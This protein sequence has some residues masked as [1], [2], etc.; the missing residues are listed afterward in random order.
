MNLKMQ[1]IVDAISK[2]VSDYRIYFKIL[3]YLIILLIFIPIACRVHS[4]WAGVDWNAFEI[5]FFWLI[6]V[7]FLTVLVYLLQIYNWKKILSL[8]GNNISFLSSF[9]IEMVSQIGKYIPGKIGLVLTKLAECNR[10]G[11]SKK[12]ALIC[13]S[14]HIGIG[15]YFQFLIGLLTVPII[16]QVV[17]DPNITFSII[18]LIFVVV[19]GIV[20]IYPK[21]FLFF[22]NLF[23]KVTGK[24]SVTIKIDLVSWLFI[25]IIY[26]ILAVLNGLIGFVMINGFFPVSFDQII[27]IIGT[28]VWAFLLGLLNI[29]APS[30]IGL[31]EGILTGLYSF[32]IPAPLALAVAITSRIVGTIVEWSL[33]GLALLIKPEKLKIQE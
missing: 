20:F 30:G 14:Y 19:I 31:R 2:I 11:I 16:L 28:R 17:K 32:I 27:Y 21:S 23:L 6:P 25:C 1:P 12:T 15:L 18:Y 24:E 22:I 5:R 26:I 10:L 9:R 33:I 4:D 7:L 13:T 3:S 8:F 29:F